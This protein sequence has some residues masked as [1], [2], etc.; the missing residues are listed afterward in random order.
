MAECTCSIIWSLYFTVIL[1]FLVTQRYNPIN[2]ALALPKCSLSLLF[3]IHSDALASI[4][5]TL[6]S[7]VLISVAWACNVLPSAY[8]S[9]ALST[10][11]GKSFTY[12]VNNRGPRI[13]LCDSPTVIDFCSDVSPS[14]WIYCHLLYK[15]EQRQFQLSP[16]TP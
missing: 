15:Y 11:S 12:R 9:T 4:S 10:Y 1:V 5:F 7:T 2:Y 14:H 13:D 3:F 16:A 6:F 8:M